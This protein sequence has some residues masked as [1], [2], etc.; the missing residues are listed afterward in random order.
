MAS[1]AKNWWEKHDMDRDGKGCFA[2]VIGI[3]GC[4]F[5]AGGAFFGLIVWGIT[6]L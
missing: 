1:F 2:I 3:L 6:K 5:I 4:A